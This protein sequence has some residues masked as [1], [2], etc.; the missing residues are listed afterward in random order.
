M[1]LSS[2][3]LSNLPKTS[4][5][6]GLHSPHLS[7]GD[8][9]LTA[10]SPLTL[11]PQPP[12]VAPV[13]TVEARAWKREQLVQA[14]QKTED[15]RRFYSV[16]TRMVRRQ[17]AVIAVREVVRRIAAAQTV[18]KAK[19]K[20]VVH[21]APHLRYKGAIPTESATWSVGSSS[22]TVSAKSPRY[23]YQRPR[24]PSSPTLCTSWKSFTTQVDA[25]KRKG[26]E[27]RS[28]EG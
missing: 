1:S 15:E 25:K 24:S 19:G 12:S 27:G 20:G 18:A 4:L 9:P 21:F 16:E 26:L 23:P 17:R 3:V 10:Y 13:W 5:K 2:K 22:K 14:H 7:Q 6:P 8:C 28:R 11:P